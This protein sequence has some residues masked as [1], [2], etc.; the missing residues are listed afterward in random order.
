MIEEKVECKRLGNEY[1]NLFE[2]VI[3]F[4]NYTPF[5]K[6]FISDN[7]LKMLSDLDLFL[8]TGKYE[9]IEFG[10]RKSPFDVTNALKEKDE[11]IS[12]LNNIIDELGK[13]LN[14]EIIRIKNISKKVK[15]PPYGQEKEYYE[16][17]ISSYSMV[18]DKLKKLKE[19]KE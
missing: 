1:K 19:G 15:V 4:I 7:D 9:I 14:D 3:Y 12:R 5:A 10:T 2:K 8:N 6:E 11:E 16:K 17:Y 18:L 13:W